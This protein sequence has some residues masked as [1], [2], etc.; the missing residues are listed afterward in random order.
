[1]RPADQALLGTRTDTASCVAELARHIIRWCKFSKD[2]ERD[3][4]NESD[5][6][7]REQDQ[8]K[9]I[10]CRVAPPEMTHQLHDRANAVADWPGRWLA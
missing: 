2:P 8:L 9:F 1:M 5:D 6:E 7:A 4:G 10:L 3:T